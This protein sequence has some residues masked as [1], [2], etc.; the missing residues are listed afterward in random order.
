MQ[1]LIYGTCDAVFA[2][3]FAKIDFAAGG[4]VRIDEPGINAYQPGKL[5]GDIVVG[6]EMLGFA[7]RGPS[8]AQGRDNDLLKVLKNGWNTCGKIIIQE[9]GARVEAVRNQS[10]VPPLDRFEDELAAI[11]KIDGRWRGDFGQ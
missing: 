11:R 2:F 5:P 7:A 3:L 4:K 10:V 6:C 1:N 9:H 8:C